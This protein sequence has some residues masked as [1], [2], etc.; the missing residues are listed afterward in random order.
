M[1]GSGS[2]LSHRA[3]RQGLCHHRRR[4]LL[5]N[6]HID[7]ALVSLCFSVADISRVFSM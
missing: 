5:F 6:L 3:K 4:S 2:H 7:E 1:R